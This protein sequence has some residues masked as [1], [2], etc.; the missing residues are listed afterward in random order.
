M[1]IEGHG[2]Q[3]FKCSWDPL[4][5]P[6][7]TQRFLHDFSQSRERPNTGQEGPETPPTYRPGTVAGWAEGQQMPRHNR[8]LVQAA[9]ILRAW[10]QTSLP[11]P[12]APAR[13]ARQGRHCRRSSADPKHL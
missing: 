7:V 5:L 13:G 1:N 4:V 2:L 11:A 3:T 8:K 12:P 10:R 9:R 6:A